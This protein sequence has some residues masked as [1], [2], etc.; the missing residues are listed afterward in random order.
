MQVGGSPLRDGN[1]SHRGTGPAHDLERRHDEQEFVD[2]LRGER[3]EVEALDDRDAAAE[4]GDVADTEIG[5]VGGKRLERGR[6]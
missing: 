4:E 1:R 6:V 2:L 5:L 3:L